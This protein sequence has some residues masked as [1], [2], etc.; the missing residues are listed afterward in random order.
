MDN[1][2]GSL[3]YFFE[4]VKDFFAWWYTFL[5]FIVGSFYFV[6]SIFYLFGHK[7]DLVIILLSLLSWALAVGEIG[8]TFK[9][10]KSQKR[11]RYIVSGII[12]VIIPLAIFVAIIGLGKSLNLPNYSDALSVAGTGMFIYAVMIRFLDARTELKR[13][14]QSEHDDD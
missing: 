2:E 6:Y 8:A 5:L 10:K 12:A 3:K 1:Q 7:S 9:D 14:Q 4:K 11:T 13:S